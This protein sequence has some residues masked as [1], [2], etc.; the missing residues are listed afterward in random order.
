MEISDIY[1]LVK[2]GH[3]L[4]EKHNYSHPIKT[5]NKIKN[6]S[7]GRIFFNLLLPDDYPLIDEPVLK[8]KLDNIISDI[9]K[10]YPKD[11]AADTISILQEEAFKL[12][13]L[14]PSSFI[15]DA[16]IMPEEWK[17][18]K[19]EFEK[20]AD[21][22]PPNEFKNKAVELTKELIQYIDDSGMTIQNVLKG[23][24]KGNPV[25]E[26]CSLLVAKG[27]IVDIEG[28]MKGPIVKGVSEG[29]S[30]TNYYDSASEARRLFYLKSIAT[31]KPGLT[32]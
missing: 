8:P 3:K 32:K 31:Q 15:I 25:D 6:M 7:I 20:I 23:G 24:V 21:K 5:G 17:K 22:L 16:F 13:T 2:T 1:Q 27:Y 12:A 10:K 28:Q 29:L 9:S 18:K 11:V 14:V 30:T 26:W 4:S 19:I